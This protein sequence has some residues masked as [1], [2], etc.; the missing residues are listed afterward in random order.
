MGLDVGIVSYIRPLLCVLFRLVMQNGRNSQRMWIVQKLDFI[1]SRNKNLPI[2][3][4]SANRPANA[5]KKKQWCG[6]NELVSSNLSAAT[7]TTTRKWKSVNSQFRCVCQWSKCE[8]Q[9]LLRTMG[10]EQFSRRPK[11][12]HSCHEDQLAFHF[13]RWLCQHNLFGIHG[14]RAKI[15]TPTNHTVEQRQI[16]NFTFCCARID[17]FSGRKRKFSRIFGNLHQYRWNSFSTNSF[18][19]KITIISGTRTNCVRDN[20]NW[21]I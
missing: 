13:V 15:A 18:V 4:P 2:I 6:R 3:L 12:H 16:M 14:R 17:L 7:T 10:C 9:H 19:N 8:H 1:R 11:R 5:C 21:M 20:A